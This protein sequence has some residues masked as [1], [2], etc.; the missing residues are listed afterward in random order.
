MVGLMSYL[1]CC[2][3]KCTYIRT[4]ARRT[5]SSGFSS[6]KSDKSLD[7]SSFFHMIHY[8]TLTRFENVDIKRSYGVQSVVLL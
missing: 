2:N 1:I 7:H 4:L 3:A 8:R 6:V 5:T